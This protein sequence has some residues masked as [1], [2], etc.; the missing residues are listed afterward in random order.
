MFTIRRFEDILFDFNEPGG[1]SHLLPGRPLEQSRRFDRERDAG[2][3]VWLTSVN[4]A[5]VNGGSLGDRPLGQIRASVGIRDS[6]VVC[7]VRLTDRNM[8][9]AIRFQV[10]CTVM[11]FG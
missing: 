3:A 7:R 6:A 11:I 8:D 1:T 5:F 9:D 4:G 10:R 2:A